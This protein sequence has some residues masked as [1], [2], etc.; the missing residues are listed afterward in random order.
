[1]S[2]GFVS[3]SED[4]IGDPSRVSDSRT[5]NDPISGPNLVKLQSQHRISV[6][7]VTYA[8]DENGPLAAKCTVMSSLAAKHNVHTINYSSH[9]DIIAER[10]Y[11][12]VFDLVLCERG[13]EY[14]NDV[15][16]CFLDLDKAFARVNCVKM[17]AGQEK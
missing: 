13:L 14:G 15:Y 3:A 7:M 17:M 2:Q 4:V 1:M 10:H 5:G 8:T 16:I 9:I 11:G 12:Y 6:I